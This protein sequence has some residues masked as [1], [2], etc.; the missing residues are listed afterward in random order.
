MATEEERAVITAILRETADPVIVDLGAHRGEDSAWMREACVTQPRI[1]LVEPDGRNLECI[2]E[3]TLDWPRCSVI[4]AAVA[5]HT[6]R[7]PFHP[8][9]NQEGHAFGSGS[10]RQP[11]GHLKYFPWCKFPRVDTITCYSLDYIFHQL[12]LGHIDVLWV[13]IQGAE[14]DMIAGGREALAHTR[15]LFMEA[16]EVE[17]YEGQATRPELLAMLPSWAVVGTF[18]ANVLLRNEAFA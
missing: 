10:I 18:E 1:V 8:C 3:A 2:R 15:Y 4:A 11:T 13:D 6:G 17:F 14:R 12:R 9:Q 7:C 5:D 16:E